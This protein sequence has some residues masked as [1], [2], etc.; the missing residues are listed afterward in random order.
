[1]VNTMRANIE[2]LCEYDFPPAG[3]LRCIGIDSVFSA[4]ASQVVWVRQLLEGKG[5]VPNP[6]PNGSQNQ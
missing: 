5:A 2:K 1:M 3:L 6:Q 4:T